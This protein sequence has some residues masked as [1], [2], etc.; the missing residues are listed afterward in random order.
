MFPLISGLPTLTASP[1]AETPG[2]APSV[3]SP[4]SISAPSARTPASA[5]GTPRSAASHLAGAAPG[6]SPF[7]PAAG[8]PLLPLALPVTGL[9][10]VGD[11][12][13]RYSLPS[14]TFAVSELGPA[15]EADKA[16]LARAMV[17]GALC[18]LLEDDQ[19][20]AATEAEA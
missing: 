16:D 2:T 1:L 6:Y 13:S 18:E 17:R 15:G 11:Q 20:E 10:L 14:V 7:T 8:F 3:P 19:A 5:A 9:G 12:A 4:A